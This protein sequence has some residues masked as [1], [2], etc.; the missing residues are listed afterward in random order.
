MKVEIIEKSKESSENDE[1][2]EEKKVVSQENE[3]EKDIDKIEILILEKKAEKLEE[4]F[5]VEEVK[6][7]E[8]VISGGR[9]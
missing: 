5:K 7:E 9:G 3:K 2:I 6:T 4:L 8:E 1:K